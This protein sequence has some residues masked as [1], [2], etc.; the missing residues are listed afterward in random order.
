MVGVIFETQR[1]EDSQW[2]RNIL[3]L[4]IDDMLKMCSTSKKLSE[5]N[6][7]SQ[8]SSRQNN[9]TFSNMEPGYQ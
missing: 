6:V 3:E 9:S 2:C 8:N 1:Q 5:G 4:M 7:N